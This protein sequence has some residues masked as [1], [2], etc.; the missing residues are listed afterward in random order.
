M[1]QA[2]KDGVCRTP[3]ITG[4]DNEKISVKCEGKEDVYRS[5]NDLLKSSHC[6]YQQL[7]ENRTLIQYLIEL[8]QKSLSS[9]RKSNPNAGGLIVAASVEHAMLIATILEN[10]CGEIPAIVT[11][12]H[13]DSQQAIQQFR[14]ANTKWIVS[15]GMISEGTDI[16]RLQVCCHLTRVK[17]E[18]YFRQVLGRILRVQNNAHED[19]L[20][21]MPAEPKLMEF[22]HRIAED[23]PSSTAVSI[24]MMEESIAPDS[25]A[26]E[27][28]TAVPQDTT[29]HIENLSDLTSL[30]LGDPD[31]GNTPLPFTSLA[32]AYETTLGLFGRFK[33]RMVSFSP[34]AG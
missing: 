20:L 27:G 2:I 13:E 32:E 12:M 30:A 14:N 23:I 29:E 26:E 19:A 33:K 3:R 6:T 15:V 16:P 17:T 4:I 10:I 18:L 7:L 11:Y 8:S 28:F 34:V 31:D 5:I 1:A 22:A 24:K 21:L 9:I 25:T